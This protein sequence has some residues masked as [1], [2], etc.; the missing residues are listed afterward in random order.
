MLAVSYTHD[1]TAASNAD[2]RKKP[3]TVSQ[4]VLGR[5][6]GKVVELDLVDCPALP[7]DVDTDVN[8]HCAIQL[9]VGGFHPAQEA[10]A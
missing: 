7:T 10:S 9:I 2:L 6:V 5:C 4:A 8:S 1:M 3:W